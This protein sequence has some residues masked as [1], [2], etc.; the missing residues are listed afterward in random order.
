VTGRTGAG[1]LLLLAVSLPLLLAAC[2]GSSSGK[3]GTIPST[4]ATH[5]R[6]HHSS[7]RSRRSPRRRHSRSRSTRTSRASS[8]SAIQLPSVLLAA[9]TKTSGCRVRSTLQDSACT[10]GATF[11]GVTTA[12]VCTLGYSSRV[13]L[14][15]SSTKR[16]VYREYG[17]A[18]HSPG[19]YEVDHLVSLELGGSNS[20]ANLWPEAAN[21]T[22][23][24]HQKDLVENYLHNQVCD[25]HISLQQAQH[26]IA[27]NWLPVYRS[28]PH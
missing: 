19:Q 26:K 7:S 6:H 17:I 22:P 27:T 24:F 14:V 21:P 28:M 4:Y 11:K 23:G 9:R 15:S 16:D 12:Q 25:G 5:T 2:G 3:Q 1:V 13:R 20:I 18:S 8:G 10:P